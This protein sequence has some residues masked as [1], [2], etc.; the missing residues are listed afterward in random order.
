MP[1]R[2]IDVPPA[3]LAGAAATLAAVPGAT[4][5]NVAEAL[6]LSTATLTRRLRDNPD[7]NT[8]PLRTM[9]SRAAEIAAHAKRAA[10]LAATELAGPDLPTVA[11]ASDRA[12]VTVAVDVTQRVL[13]R[14]RKEWE[15]PRGLLAE[16][17]KARSTKGT[18]EA[19]DMAKLAKIS[20]E[21][22]TLV[23]SGERTA[24]GIKSGEISPVIEIER[25]E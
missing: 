18:Q 8:R 19:F 13:E 21:T 2:R 23:Q 14:H 17:V 4:V 25:D 5:P 1:P 6:G 10:D 12:A 3:T 9:D 24:H 22:L 20:A 11:Q 15:V 16:A 7:L